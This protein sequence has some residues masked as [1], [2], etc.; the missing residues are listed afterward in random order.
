MWSMIC[1]IKEYVTCNMN[2]WICQTSAS[3]EIYYV[4][5]RWL[6][7]IPLYTWVMSLCIW[8]M[9]LF[10]WIDAGADFWEIRVT[11][12]IFFCITYYGLRMMSYYLLHIISYCML[13]I[14][15]RLHITHYFMVCYICI[16]TEDR[17]SVGKDA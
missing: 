11:Y 17:K 1:N 15:S 13:H 7:R 10:Y 8:V 2:L 5:W 3:C 16:F 4:N 6:L 14:M 9:S 12:C